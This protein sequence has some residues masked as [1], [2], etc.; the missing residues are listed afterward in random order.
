MVLLD[1]VEQS[2]ISVEPHVMIGNGH[3][4]EGDLFGVLEVGIGAPNA[5][6]PF[7]VQQPVIHQH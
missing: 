2:A 5:L 4:L 7:H 6:Q 1:D 3:R